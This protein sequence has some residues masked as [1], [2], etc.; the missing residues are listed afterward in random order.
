MPDTS[1]EIVHGNY[2]RLLQVVLNLVSNA[3]KFT[4]K[5]ALPSAPM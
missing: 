1:D 3:L 2:Q 4:L 5:V